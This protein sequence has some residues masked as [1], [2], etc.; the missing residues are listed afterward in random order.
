VPLL[1]HVESV[2]GAVVMIRDAN[3]SFPMERFH[4]RVEAVVGWTPRQRPWY[5]RAVA[6]VP[7]EGRRP[8]RKLVV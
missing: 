7:T 4:G 6:F 3:R 2:R 1:L 8:C 5:A